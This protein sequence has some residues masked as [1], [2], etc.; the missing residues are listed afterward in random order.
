MKVWKRVTQTLGDI[1]APCLMGVLLGTTGVLF[2][3]LPISPTNDST[4]GESIFGKEKPKGGK[5]RVTSE[6]DWK[7]YYGSCP[8][9]KDDIKNSVKKILVEP[10]S[11]SMG[12]QEGSTMKKQDN[13]FFTTF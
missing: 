5:R 2:I 11:P 8:E 12:H 9:L 1:W 4:L 13:F 3:K 10:Y 7:R 6:S